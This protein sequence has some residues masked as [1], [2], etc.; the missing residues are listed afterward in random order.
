MPG[1]KKTIILDG[2]DF[3]W[4]E[5]DI[6]RVVAMHNKGHHINDISKNLKRNSAEVLM[7][8][9]HVAVQGEVGIRP[10]YKG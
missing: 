3:M 9:I 1:D 10:L 4:S 2:M 8:L 6:D 5:K 7:A